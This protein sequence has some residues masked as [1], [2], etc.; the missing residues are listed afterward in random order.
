ML[1]EASAAPAVCRIARDTMG[2]GYMPHPDQLAA[3]QS[4]GILIAVADDG[5]TI[6]GFSVFSYPQRGCLQE[7]L[8]LSGPIA[9]P[10]AVRRSDATG[11]IAVI[12]ILAVDPGFQRQGIGRRLF[13]ATETEA[14]APHPQVVIVAAWRI[15]SALPLGRILT[16]SGYTRWA[17]LDEHWRNACDGGAFSC[18]HRGECCVCSLVL[19]GKF[20]P[21]I[22]L[23]RNG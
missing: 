6:L 14:V 10:D 2:D 13:E 23:S 21:D 12:E 8:R 16:T 4:A 7:R 5:R 18:P 3:D 11:S 20:L 15:G 17:M 19:F 1:Y 22:C 9:L